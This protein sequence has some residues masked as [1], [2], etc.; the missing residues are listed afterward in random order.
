LSGLTIKE[1]AARSLSR[2]YT[3]L[4]ASL[5]ADERLLNRADARGQLASA[6]KQAIAAA[7]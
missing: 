7:A 3:S 1:L 6:P 5:L 2:S 4:S